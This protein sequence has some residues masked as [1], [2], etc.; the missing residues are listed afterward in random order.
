MDTLR[1][2]GAAMASGIRATPRSVRRHAAQTDF[3]PDE[4]W[5]HAER[6]LERTEVYGVSCVARVA[7]EHVL[8]PWV[9]FGILTEN[10]R[11]AALRLKRDFLAA[12]LDAHWVGA[13]AP[14]GFGGTDER[15]EAEEEAYTRWRQA[16]RAMGCPYNNVVATAVCHDKIPPLE[17]KIFLQTGLERLEK[18]YAHRCSTVGPSCSKA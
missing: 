3:G 2:G 11:A 4:R 9:R 13:Y 6:K 7:E 1:A 10:M 14:H 16:M 18:W 5:Q 17:M 12:R 15:S 8:D